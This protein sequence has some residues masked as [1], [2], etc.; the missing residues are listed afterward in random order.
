[1]KLL[2]RIPRHVSAHSHSHRAPGE[3]RHAAPALLSPK[4]RQLPSLPL[5]RREECSVNP[6][7]FPSSVPQSLTAGGSPKISHFPRPR[8]VTELAGLRRRLCLSVCLVVCLDVWQGLC[9]DL[10]LIL[11]SLADLHPVRYTRHADSIYIQLPIFCS[12]LR[13]F[14]S[15]IPSSRML[16]FPRTCTR[17][18][19]G[20][21]FGGGFGV[22][23]SSRDRPVKVPVPA[24]RAILS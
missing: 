11:R 18:G 9:V 17:E 15:Q 16:C 19:L 21:G 2:I 5:L 24:A 20:G 1:M 22:G 23:G 4:E 7:S 13:Y 3:A 8:S 14:G 12:S 6:I 10:L